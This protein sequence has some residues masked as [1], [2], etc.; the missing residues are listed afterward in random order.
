[1]KYY[2]A[3][4]S[5]SGHS[6]LV[7]QAR[8]ELAELR[9]RAERR[10]AALREQLERAE[11]AEEL[12]RKGEFLLAYMHTLAPGQRTLTIPEERLTIDLDPA[13]TPV[14]NAQALFREYHKARSA[15]E[16]LP[17]LVEQAEMQVRYLDELETSL[18]L[19]ARYD[20]IRAVQA[21]IKQARSPSRQ[22]RDEETRGPAGKQGKARGGQGKLPQPLRLKTRNGVPLL[23]GRTARQNDAATFRLAAP[24]DLWFHA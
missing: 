5:L 8:A 18:D 2:A 12:R 11:S 10:V 15:Q 17:A 19:A 7:A 4:E 9:S 3:L 20:D 23:V 24:D 14:E 22:R 13:L 21:E 16:G 6:A 1:S